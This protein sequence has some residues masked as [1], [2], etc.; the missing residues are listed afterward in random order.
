MTFDNE[1]LKSAALAIREGSELQGADAHEAMV[2]FE[3]LATPDA[4][5]SL[6]AQ[7]ERLQAGVDSDWAEVERIQ[8]IYTEQ[9]RKARALRIER[10]QLKTDN[11]AWRLILEAERRIKRVTAEEI[12]P[13]KAQNE[14]MRRFLAEVSR[15]SGD[16]WAVM[17][18]RNLL[19]EFGHD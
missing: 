8:G 11:E 14:K 12:G 18:A 10:D 7:I 5:L 13:V 9:L 3:G 6:I 19:K 1:K 4:V 16:K 15:T 2:K 17:A